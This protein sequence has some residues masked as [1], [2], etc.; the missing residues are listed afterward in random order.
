MAGRRLASAA[1]RRLGAW[2]RTLQSKR[3]MGQMTW[4]LNQRRMQSSWKRWLHGSI[5]TQSLAA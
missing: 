2:R 3:H 5:F 4:S 1:D